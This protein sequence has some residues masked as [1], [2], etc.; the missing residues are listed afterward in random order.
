[1]TSFTIHDII[2]FEGK[3]HVNILLCEKMA[4]RKRGLSNAEIQRLL[5]ESDDSDSDD[6]GEISDVV[7]TE[8]ESEENEESDDSAP[9]S[10]SWTFDW[11][12]DDVETRTRLPFTGTPGRRVPVS[13]TTDPVQYL[14]LLLTDD[15][16]DQV[17]IETNRRAQQIA[18]SSHLRRRSRFNSWVDVTRDE[19]KVL[20]ALF[21]Y[22]GIIQK[23]EVELYWSKKPLIE[24]PYI[25]NIM[26]ENRFGLLMKC[27][28]FVDNSTI[29]DSLSP[30]EKSYW[31]IKNFFEALIER[32]SSVYIPEAHVAI[33]E[34]LM[35]WKGRLPMK[36]Y[37][38]LKKARF[39]LKS[40]ELCESGTGYI[41][42]CIVHTGT[43][44]KLEESVDGLTS[45]RIVLTLAKELLN[46]GYCIFMDNWY[47]SPGLYRE[48]KLKQ[49][50]A[51]G[52]VRL[53]RKNMP[54][55][56][57]KK[58]LRG[59]TTANFT[60]DMMA[61]KWMDKK[62]VTVL[63]TFHRNEMSIVRSYRGD[64]EKPTAV[65]LYNSNM[66]AVDVADQM[67]SAYPAERKRHKVWY[68]KQFRHLLNQV[69]LNSYILHK[70]DNADSK[71]THLQFRLQLIER[72]LECHHKPS[73]LPRRGRPS[74]D[75]L[76]PL[77]LTARHFP[78]F[79]P[80]NDNKE[81]PTRRCKVCCSK[82]GEDGK[83]V[84][85]E[86]RYFCVECDVALCP[87]P[88]FGLYHTKKSY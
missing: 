49:T 66:G 55:E 10:S 41:W 77:R 8:T 4:G 44:M 11:S 29:S 62:E 75:E 87:A 73:Q 53:N 16:L 59:L 65:L 46:K 15:I 35:L 32:F 22:Q 14:D 86:T 70:K 60:H 2:Y 45:S 83:K 18:Q 40:Y 72:L 26:S 74:I 23:P 88:C 56:L 20:F 67:L 17:V 48:L 47:S 63:S 58:I 7:T 50:D 25:R 33:D 82:C 69:V 85:K 31:K 57:K 51:V 43:S 71:L 21:I 61:V 84:R 36:Q 24:T 79:I 78:A 80:G 19:L 34:S 42:K 54:V 30:A 12:K 64:K 38:P 6:E 1:M 52:T 76:N 39:G 13:D 68:K 28:H 3:L 37:I 27:L 81:A 5:S 9:R